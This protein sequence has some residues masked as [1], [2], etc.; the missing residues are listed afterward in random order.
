M[1]GKQKSM[2]LKASAIIKYFLGTNDEIETLIMCKPTN[3]ELV[4]YDQSLYE[5]LGSIKDKD[6]F[7]FRKLVKFLESV[8][9][10]SFKKNLKKEKPLLTD[11][12]VKE[13]RKGAQK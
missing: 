8:D 3:V 12:R 2:F 5:A 13:L 4:C 11:K 1:M 6:E 9:V 7:N 10:V